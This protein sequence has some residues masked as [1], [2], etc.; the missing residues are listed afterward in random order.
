MIYAELL[1]VIDKNT[2]EFL[3]LAWHHEH[4][5]HQTKGKVKRYHLN[6]KDF[7]LNIA[8]V[9]FEEDFKEIKTMVFEKMNS[10]V[11]SSSLVEMVNSIIRTYLN[12]SKGQITQESLNLIMFYHNHRKY[13]SGKRKGMAPI[14]LL[15]GNKLEDHWSNLL[16]KEV[17]TK[18]DNSILFPQPSSKLYEGSENII[19]SEQNKAN[20]QDQ[21]A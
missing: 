10:L 11:R 1:E 13:K 4:F 17:K 5:F 14:E 19:D 20:L 15:T 7:W 21:T 6:E 9:R 16:I 2:L 12:N 8:E 18:R 3:T